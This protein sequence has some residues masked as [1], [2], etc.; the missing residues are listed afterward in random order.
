MPPAAVK[1]PTEENTPASEIWGWA[2]AGTGLSLAR[3]NTRL[4]TACE[5]AGYEMFMPT[6][7]S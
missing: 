4:Y 2:W 1:K 5:R 6:E 3:D 7:H